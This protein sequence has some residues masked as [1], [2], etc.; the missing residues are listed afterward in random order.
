MGIKRFILFGGLLLV[1]IG[2]YVYYFVDSDTK[3]LT[4]YGLDYFNIPNKFNI[5]NAIWMIVPAFI[6]Y[7]L[8]II[9]LLFYLNLKNRAEKK[10]INDKNSV[11]ELLIQKML[12]KNNPKKL[13]FKTNYFN[14]VRDFVHNIKG[15]D[16]D[17]S[18]K[19]DNIK[20]NDIINNISTINK[21]EVAED[22][23]FKSNK[24][25][26]KNSLYIQNELNKLSIDPLYAEKYI[27]HYSKLQNEDLKKSVA[28]IIVNSKDIKVIK[29][30]NLDLTSDQIFKILEKTTTKEDFIYFANQDCFEKEDFVQVV[31]RFKSKFTP[32]TMIEIFTELS[33][34]NEKAYEALIYIHFEYEKLDTVEDLIQNRYEYI[35]YTL[36]LKLKKSGEHFDIS[37]FI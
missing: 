25:S 8:T 27:R 3:T 36:L 14:T 32:S 7:I 19:V 30:M 1:S 22:R 6:L 12:K 13:T 33:Q 5:F 21:G 2:L 29:K 24:L 35:K 11:N 37:M 28:D 18:V 15:F 20:I 16:L 26:S 17:S 23:F 4:I 10:I 34:K 31:K 9:H